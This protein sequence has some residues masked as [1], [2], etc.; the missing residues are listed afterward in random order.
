[1]PEHLQGAVLLPPTA[2]QYATDRLEVDV[3]ACSNGED[4]GK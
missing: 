4:P 1:M 3:G 2:P